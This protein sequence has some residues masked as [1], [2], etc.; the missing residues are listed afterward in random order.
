MTKKEI[1][2]EDI[3]NKI[4]TGEIAQG[5]WITE[6][7]MG[8]RYNMSRTP[9]REILWNLATLNLIE[10][11][12]DR[13][14]RVKKYTIEDIIEVFNARKAIE[15][16]CARLACISTDDSY[17]QKVNELRDKLLATSLEKTAELVEIGI[18]VH[19][20]VQEQ[21]HNKYLNEFNAR[22]DSLGAIIRNTTK[23]YQNIEIKSR[24]GHLEILNALAQRD[25]NLCATAM[26]KHLQDT[27]VA[28]V[29]NNCITLLGNDD[30]VLNK[31]EG[32]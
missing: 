12:G 3:K 27:C 15:G 11:T 25:G 10:S 16:E 8:E 26:R 1:V 17:M 30:F 7:E 4:I 32:V 29:K 24:D 14:Y 23:S 5:T 9:I 21:S 2:L 18:K 13:G 19:V 6:R 28:M 22:I 31:G 20:F